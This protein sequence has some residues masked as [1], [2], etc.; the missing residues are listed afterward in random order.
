MRGRS[1][2]FYIQYSVEGAGGKGQEEGLIS[3]SNRL[4]QLRYCLSCFQSFP[5]L[6]GGSSESGTNISYAG[7]QGQRSKIEIVLLKLGQLGGMSQR[8]YCFQRVGE[9]GQWSKCDCTVT[10]GKDMWLPL[11]TPSCMLT[12]HHKID[13]VVTSGGMKDMQYVVVHA[14]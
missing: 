9:Q 11:F 14:Y 10:T 4:L 7:Q 12:S 2:A 13:M 6:L 5:L 1:Y 8:D 3:K